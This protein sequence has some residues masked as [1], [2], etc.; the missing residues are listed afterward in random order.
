M[1]NRE[2]KSDVFSML[3][4]E[5]ENALQ[6]YNG[7]NNTNY[8]DPSQVVYNT[9]EKGISL[10]V[11]NEKRIPIRTLHFVLFYNGIDKMR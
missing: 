9:L 7:L 5:P 3:M 8:T 10:T 1:S 2:Y 4:Q 6:V 11:R